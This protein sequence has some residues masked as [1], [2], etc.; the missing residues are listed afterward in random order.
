MED[1]ATPVNQ[2]GGWPPSASDSTCQ[3]KPCDLIPA[4][5][6]MDLSDAKPSSEKK[7]SKAGKGRQG[8]KNNKRFQAK[9]KPH[10]IN[11]DDDLPFDHHSRFPTA[12][13]PREADL[14]YEI[15]PDDLPTSLQHG[16]PP[17]MTSRVAGTFWG[18]LPAAVRTTQAKARQ[19]MGIW[20]ATKRQ[21]DATKADDEASQ[22]HL[23]QHHLQQHNAR[24]AFAHLR[25][26]NTEPPDIALPEPCE[27]QPPP[28]PTSFSDGSLA[29]SKE[30]SFCL[31]GAWGLAPR[32]ADEQRR[33]HRD[34]GQLG[35]PITRSHRTKAQHPPA[36]AWWVLHSD[37]NSGSHHCSGCTRASP[38]RH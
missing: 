20:D 37:G 15:Q 2:A 32:Q 25:G 21:R 8:H 28:Q 14:W 36:R 17:D 34:R 23:T 10:P 31:G 3:T 26:A 4:H 9:A 35:C 27:E 13:Q 22:K 38:C 33:P 30:P 7:Q 16:L 5:R 19:L 24:Q 1:A 6:P 11:I 12:C 29:H 18:M